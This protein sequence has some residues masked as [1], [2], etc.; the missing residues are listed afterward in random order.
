MKMLNDST[1]PIKLDQQQFSET[2][3]VS[4]SRQS[5]NDDIQTM[6]QM[7]CD[8]PK[9]EDEEENAMQTREMLDIRNDILKPLTRSIF[10]QF[11]DENK[12]R[13]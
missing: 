6:I 4:K 8:V 2:V 12:V 9:G 11:C 3:K 10:E 7:E 1:K 5:N 13:N